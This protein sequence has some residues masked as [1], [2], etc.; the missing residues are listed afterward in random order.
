MIR[1]TLVADGILIHVQL[2]GGSCIESKETIKPHEID[3]NY[4]ID[5]N[6][7]IVGYDP[8]KVKKDAIIIR[9][10]KNITNSETINDKEKLTNWFNNWTIGFG[11]LFALILLMIGVWG[12]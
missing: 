1:E 2:H 4:F 7:I 8:V 6:H 5:L 9:E 11:F 10:L 3:G 12:L